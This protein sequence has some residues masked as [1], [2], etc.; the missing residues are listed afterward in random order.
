M[1]KALKDKD[2]VIEKTD[3]ALKDLYGE[4]ERTNEALERTKASLETKVDERTKELEASNKALSKELTERKKMQEVLRTPA[5]Q[6]RTTFDAIS[7]VIF[8]TDSEGRIL[9]C[10]TAMADFL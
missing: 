4:L 9:R 5:R 10:N 7:D 8:L 6:W 2:W 3:A 1:Q